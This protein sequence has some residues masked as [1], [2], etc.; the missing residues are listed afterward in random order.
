M[1]GIRTGVVTDTAVVGSA[2]LDHARRVEDSGVDTLLI[3]DHFAVDAFGPQLA[4]FSALAS[5]AAV[6]ERLQVGTLVLSNDF[7]HPVIVAHEAASLHEISG[8]RFELGMGAGWY[9]PEYDAAGMTFD[10]AGR[11]IDRLE[12]ALTIITGLLAGDRVDFAGEFYRI[13]DL[14]LSVLPQRHGRPKLL[15]GAG[16]PRMLALAARYADVVGVLPAPITASDGGEDPDDRLPAAFDQKLSALRTA[17]GDRF[18]RLEISAFVTIRVT[19]HRRSDT[20]QLIAE[21]GWSGLEVEQVWEMPTVFI[22]SATQ[23]RED[24]LLRRERF[25]LSYLVTSDQD[26]PTLARLL[27]TSPGCR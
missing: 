18:A 19:D 26:L 11:R 22:G 21:R 25:G 14:D 24:I 23:I 17:A 1:P 2:W 6:T 9:E 4:P 20:E 13:D 15:V 3:R 5:A 12:E 7:R 16:G 8:G 10:R 27:A